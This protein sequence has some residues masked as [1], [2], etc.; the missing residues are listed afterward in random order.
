M[1][2]IVEASDGTNPRPGNTAGRKERMRLALYIRTVRSGQGTE[3]VIVNLAKGLARRGHAV[4]LLLEELGGAV[5]EGLPAGVTVVLLRENGVD[6]IVGAV[7]RLRCLIATLAAM[8]SDGRLRMPGLAPAFLRLAWGRRPPLH[9]LNRY[10]RRAAPASVT[11]FLNHPCFVL[12]LATPGEGTRLLV[13]VRNHVSTSSAHAETRWNREVPILMAALYR[14]ADRVIAVSEGVRADV[15]RITG[16]APKKTVTIHNP[17]Y[18]DWIA[19]RAAEPS[20]HPW[21]DDPDGP[22]VLVAAGKLRPQKD[23][24]TLI[25][26]FAAVRKAR[27]VRLIILGEGAQ[28]QE[29]EQLARDLGVDSDL[30]MPG[31]VDNPYAYFARSAAFV[32]SSA[33]EGFPNVL[34]EAMACGAPVVSTDCPSGP[35]EILDSGRFGPLVPVGDAAGLADAIETVLRAPPDRALMR[36]RTRAYDSEAILD[37]YEALLTDATPVV[38]R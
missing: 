12:L 14:N 22:P 23:F 13:S 3:K 27:P 7:A 9:A 19:E 1:S 18:L 6:R 35:S 5:L 31:H 29:L 38:K 2:S 15:E 11:A 33:W 21:L 34:V 10:L 37:A 24:P 25:R 26:A 16:L 30:A 32:L 4:D 36:E 8:A 20:G 28:R 17:Y